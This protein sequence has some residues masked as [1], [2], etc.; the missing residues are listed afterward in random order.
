MTG[1]NPLV[2]LCQLTT[3]TTGTG[4]ITLGAAS[5]GYRG[6][7]ALTN[8]TTYSYSIIDGTNY[9]LGQGAYTSSGTTLAR[10]PVQSSSANAAITLSGTAIVIVGDALA[11]DISAFKDAAAAPSSPT[12]GDRFFDNTSG[13]SYTYITDANGSQ[14]VETSAAGTPTNGVFSTM[15]LGGATLGSN[16]LAVTGTTSLSI[17]LA[18]A[19]GGTGLAVAIPN[20]IGGLTLSTAGSSATFGIATGGATDTTNAVIM[21][22][23]SAYTKTTSAWAVGTGN[24]SLDTGTIAVSTWYHVYIIQSTAG[25][26]DVLI[27]TSATSPTLPSGYSYKR[28]IGSMRTNGSSQ[29]YGFTQVQN[30]FTWAVP[31]DDWQYPALPGSATLKAMTVPTSINVVALLNVALDQGPATAYMTVWSPSQSQ[32]TTPTLVLMLLTTSSP[33]VAC[34]IQ[35]LTNT[36][37]QVY[38]IGTSTSGWQETTL[39][40]IDFRGS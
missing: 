30:N 15:A 23:T 28:R 32:P 40:W 22:L 16:A 5:S 8:G 1:P 21:A 2:N 17:P 19:S 39:G 27:S 25:V 36:S 33:A 38:V 10:G 6:T 4:T 26:V 7:S 3:A 20:Y 24:G 34:Q 13:I 29:W 12:E 35:V 31:F 18:T 37:A 14:W 9:E 11:W